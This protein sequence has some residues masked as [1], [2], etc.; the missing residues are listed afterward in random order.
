MNKIVF[1]GL[2]LVTTTVGVLSTTGCS[3]S[4]D[5]GRTVSA[6]SALDTF[7]NP[8]GSFDKSNASQAFSGFRSEKSE[9]GK[10]SQPGAGGGGSSGTSSKQS[11][12][13][14]TRTLDAK[15]QCTE[16]QTCACEGSGSFVL[17]AEQSKAGQAAHIT[18]D[19]CLDKDGSGFD[20][21]ALLVVSSQPILGIS[22]E[23]ASSSAPATGNGTNAAADKNIL[24]AAKGTAYEASQSLELEF[25][26][27][28][29]SGY[30]LLAIQVPDGKIVIG[31]NSR[32]G[33]A[34]VKAKQGTWVCKAGKAGKG[35]ACSSTSGGEEVDIED[36]D[37]SPAVSDV[38]SGEKN[39]IPGDEGGEGEGEGDGSSAGL[40]EAYPNESGDDF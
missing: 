40:E 33:D 9:S 32:N 20:G 18:F 10:V 2:L 17:T 11:L 36:A 34:F 19:K 27:L 15:S 29:E 12:K 5:S 7:Q 22:S 23:A 1:T 16:G 35:Y 31:V 30:M 4:E 28:Q 39:S 37:A 24:F 13:L 6:D 14:L 3:S 21:E 8:T 25:A 38:A 26:L